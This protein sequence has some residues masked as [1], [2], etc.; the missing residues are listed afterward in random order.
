MARFSP[1]R[2]PGPALPPNGVEPI[3]GAVGPVT[4][5]QAAEWVRAAAEDLGPHTLHL[6]QSGQSVLHDGRSHTW[7]FLLRLPGLGCSGL[8][9][10]Q[11]G[12]DDDPDSPPLSL[13]REFLPLPD[14][15]ATPPAV[16]WSFTDSPDV[17][18]A[19]TRA[20]ADF[21]AGP[22]DMGIRSSFADDGTLH[23]QTDMYDGTIDVPEPSP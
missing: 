19:L 15:A 2:K 14:D 12:D 16:A 3:P 21:V 9:S 4:S 5:Q 22:T 7:E 8:L 17:V 6:V 23:W 20:G 13:W 11:P 10:V 18:A 1:F